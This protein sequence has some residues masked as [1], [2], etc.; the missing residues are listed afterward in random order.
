MAAG[1]LVLEREA[2]FGRTVERV[3][4]RY[5]RVTRERSCESTKRAID[6][7]TQWNGLVF[8]A[9]LPRG[10]GID[11]LDYARHHECDVPAIVLGTSFV[12]DAAERSFALGAFF[13]VDLTDTSLE[14]W[15]SHA[16]RAPR[17]PSSV[18]STL[19]SWIDRYR[20]TAAETEIL[21]DAT[22][23]SVHKDITLKHGVSANTIKRHV[24]NVLEKTGDDTLN[25]AALR[26]LREALSVL[27]SSSD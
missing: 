21:R 10:D 6:S 16:I 7:E 17:A 14:R 27:S 11:L 2:I 1:F 3:L 19:R 20:L 22:E 13:V 23:G 12:P 18:D 9:C 26:L 5:A 25:G 8:D 4:A 24:R 15:A